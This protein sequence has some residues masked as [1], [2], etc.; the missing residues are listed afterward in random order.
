VK[1]VEKCLQEV[2]RNDSSIAESSVKGNIPEVG[3]I[4]FDPK[5][6]YTK[7]RQF[8][9][10]CNEWIRTEGGA[11][12]TIFACYCN[13]SLV[14]AKNHDTF[15]QKGMIFTNS[16]GKTK[17]SLVM[18]GEK[19]CQWK[20]KY[21]SLTF[22]QCGKG[23]PVEG[24]NEAGLV[25][26]QATLPETVYP[27]KDEKSE[28]SCLETIQYLLDLGGSVPEA[29]ELF[30]TFRINPS[31]WPL[32]Y[33]LC[34]PS[35]ERAIVE[36]LGG[37]MRLYKGPLLE[38]PVLTNVPYEV[39][40]EEIRETQGDFSEDYRGNALE[41]FRRVVRG[42][43]KKE[44]ISL[45]ETL[46]LLDGAKRSD[47]AW[48]CVYDL[49]NR[50]ILFTSVYD[51]RPQ[52]ISLHDVDLSESGLSLLYDLETPGE[53]FAFEPYSREKNRKNIEGFFNNETMV[54]MMN[55]PS[56]DFVIHAY[57]NHIHS[58]ETGK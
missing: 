53:S 14:V 51:R 44:S 52:K 9:L 32:H 40:L 18:P 30:G 11:M 12:C 16:R 46:E 17:R 34:D 28:I 1:D 2:L 15:I 24:M 54:S 8:V 41:R 56:A 48:Q 7:A 36:F 29:L 26:E 55:L 33:F 47:T 58:I 5:H 10:G 39:A 20:S 3:E 38:K 57:D 31:S 21:G 13:E 19:V 25:V 42:L 35:G 23:M 22:S 49:Q 50:E 4:I 45:S 37:K 27:A 6:P 43:E